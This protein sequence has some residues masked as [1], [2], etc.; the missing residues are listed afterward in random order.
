M[1]INFTRLAEKHFPLILEWLN[2]PHVNQ[3]EDE[4]AWTLEKVQTK[5]APYIQGIIDIEGNQRTIASY[6]IEF[7]GRSIGYIQYYRSTDA[8]RNGA[9]IDFFIGEPDLLRKGIGTE[10]LSL[11]LHLYVF[12]EYDFCI[13]DPDSE[14]IAAIRTC[15]NAGFQV[16]SSFNDFQLMVAFPG[17]EIQKDL[18]P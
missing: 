16:H 13:V 6:I 11:F 8:P 17:V 10:C 18:Q 14:N 1:N 4:K 7:D 12:G 15:E 9:A 3:W 2:Q 5:Y